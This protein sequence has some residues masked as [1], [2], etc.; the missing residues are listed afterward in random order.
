M[1]CKKRKVLGQHYAGNA[2]FYARFT[3]ATQGPKAISRD[4][5]QPCYWSLLVYVVIVAFLAQNLALHALRT[6]RCARKVGKN[7]IFTNKLI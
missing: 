1:P 4:K 2:R 7:A 5:F 6:L 3:Q